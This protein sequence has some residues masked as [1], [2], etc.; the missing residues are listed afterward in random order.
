MSTF[1]KSPAYHSWANM[2]TRVRTRPGYAHVKIH[3]P[4]QKFK[5]FIADMGERPEG[6][7]LDR[8]NND[9]NYEPDNCRWADHETQQNNK[10][11]NIITPDCTDRMR[12]MARL[13]VSQRAI[14]RWFG[15]SQTTVFDRLSGRKKVT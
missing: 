4:W 6:T 9:G 11:N 1:V 7:T 13:G 3:P 5:N 10:S 2:K 12:D 8:I 15:V 14:G